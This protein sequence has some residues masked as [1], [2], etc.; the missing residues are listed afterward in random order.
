M[1]RI[2]SRF[3]SMVLAT[4]LLAPAARAAEPPP[5]RSA[6]PPDA[7]A[8]APA[9][10]AYTDDVLFGEVWLRPGLSQRD[11]SFVTI[12][13]LISAGQ[14]QQLR[15]HLNRALS[16]GV[17][18][19]EIAGLLAH[20]AFY[21]GW[22]RAMSAASV[23]K[24][25]FDERRIPPLKLTTELLP[26][27]AASDAPR[28]ARVAAEAG[29]TSP[30]L[31]AFTNETLFKNLWRS[32]ELSPRDRSLATIVALISMGAAEQL[33]FH[34]NRALDNGLTRAQL[35]EVITQLGFYTG[36]PRAMSAVTVINAAYK[37]RDAPP[38]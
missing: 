11:R 17:T 9:L 38:P 28:A 35:G 12:T 21:S 19:T 15:N 18:P 20:L 30:A 31:A 27:D 16:N 6:A 8:V 26:Y 24:Q 3:Q 22:P 5:R 33:P 25:V 2:P 36:W 23:T 29:T 13:A 34:V 7:I 32:P 37:Q 1:F 4:F 10:A 14:A